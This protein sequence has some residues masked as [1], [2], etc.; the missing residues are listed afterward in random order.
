MAA[1]ITL[2]LG[3][4]KSCISR[5]IKR[6]SVDEN[7]CHNLAQ[8]QADSRRANAKKSILTD[9]NWTTIRS[10]LQQKWSREQISGWLR[11]N[12]NI[13]FY[14]SDQWIYD[15]IYADRAQD[16]M[17]YEHLRRGGQP[18]KNG[19]KNNIAVKLKIVLISVLAQI[20]LIN[21][22]A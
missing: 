20:L 5:E 6:N 16:G 18:Y 12:P 14:V 2:Q 15:Y 7:Y 4:S 19:G 1:H 17:L 8:K 22:N 9:D 13:G 3:R 21:V 11:E 10:L